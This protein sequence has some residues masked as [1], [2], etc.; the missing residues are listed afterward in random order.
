MCR[1]SKDCACHVES[2][3]KTLGIRSSDPWTGLFGIRTGEGKLTLGIR[4][5]VKAG[6]NGVDPKIVITGVNP[7]TGLNT[8]DYDSEDLRDKWRVD[9]MLRE[10]K[11][12]RKAE[13]KSKA[14]AKARAATIKGRRMRA[15][16]GTMTLHDK[17]E[18]VRTMARIE[19]L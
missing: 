15:A 6:T 17:V 10:A 4:F 12:D 1:C 9:A 5:P 2:D 3:K 16:M 13:R 19:K 7:D 14:L 18:I 8:W 11:A